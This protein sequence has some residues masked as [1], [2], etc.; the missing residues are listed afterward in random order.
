MTGLPSCLLHTRDAALARRVRGFLSRIAAVRHADTLTKLENALERAGAA[1]LLLDVR[2]EGALDALPSIL[3]T[4]PRTVVIALGAPGSDPVVDAESL[5]IYASEELEF[6]RGRFQSLV[7]RALEHLRLRQENE[8]LRRAATAPPAPA[9]ADP[10]AARRA[11]LHPTRR[12][13][14]A[15]RPFSDVESL[16]ESLA[17]DLAGAVRVSR[18][19]IFCRA[20]GSGRYRLRGGLRCL[21]DTR[22]MEYTDRDPL[23]RWLALH[24]H[25]VARVNLD[26]LRDTKAR[27]LLEETLDRLGAEVIVPLQARNEL[28]GWLFAGQRATGVPFEQD[29]LEDLLLVTEH[30]ST[31]LENA[32][33]YEEMTVQKSLAETLLHAMPTGIVA[34]GT[35]GVIRWYNEAARQIL[36][37]PDDDALNQRAEVLGSHLADLLRRALAGDEATGAADE[38]TDPKTKRLLALQTRRLASGDL[39]LGAV[40]LLRDLTVERMLQEKQDQLERTAFWT[41]LAASMSHEVR[42]PLVAIKTFAQLLPERYEDEEF[43]T[44]FSGIVSDEVDRLNRIIDEIN[45]FA[46]PP[47]LEFKPLDVRQA[48]KRALD[49][50]LRSHAKNGV[51]VDTSIEERLPDIEGDGRALSE[52]FAHIINNAIEALS[53]RDNPRVVLTA[54]EYRDGDLLSGVAVSVQDNA[55]GIPDELRDK[56]F[57]P[58]C[59]SKARGMGLGL[60]IAKRTVVDHDGRLNIETSGEGT[61][62]TVVLPGRRGGN[63]SHEA[64]TDR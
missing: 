32:L 2:A 64:R 61:C 55:G 49:S 44:Q 30:V 7:G 12:F 51:W 8:A 22:E 58:F 47:K 43:R 4:W 23:V 40:A 35:D 16:I 15:L 46:H 9:R 52:C 62:V 20:R 54:R 36:E 28:L 34:V 39:C 5:G 19:G 6:E 42:N 31:T 17:E 21:D 38:W 53:G 59:T 63:G 27:M 18:V 50:A 11:A 41:E 57:S 10:P 13:P 37:V 33:L 48:V 56:V 3:K 24:A 60:P 25:M 29:D 14:G 26:H 1:V 45:C